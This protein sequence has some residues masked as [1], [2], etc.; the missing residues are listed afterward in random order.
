MEKKA[1]SD[2]ERQK[3]R[4]QRL[5]AKADE[6]KFAPEGYIAEAV[7]NLALAKVIPETLITRICQDAAWIAKKQNPELTV[8]LQKYAEKKI[9]GFF[10]PEES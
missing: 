7:R 4:R 5:K 10:I 3:R 8:I 2:A 6:A 1:L 9:N